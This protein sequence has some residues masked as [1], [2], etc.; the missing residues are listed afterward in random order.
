M[1]TLKQPNVELVHTG[2]ERIES[3]GVRTVDGELRAADV[4]CYATGFRHNDF[5]DTIELTGRNGVSLRAQWGDE[6][7]H[8]QIGA[9]RARALVPWLHRYNHP[10]HRTAISEPPARR[11]NNVAGHS[12]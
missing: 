2:I 8:L 9:S 12:A 1:R 3:E 4:I 7:A 10:R 11:I 6:T 5:L